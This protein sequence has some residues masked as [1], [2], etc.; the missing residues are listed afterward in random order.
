MKC[1]SCGN[2]VEIGKKNIVRKGKGNPSYSIQCQICG[3]WNTVK[4][5]H[6]T[7]EK[8]TVRISQ[9]PPL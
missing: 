3:K 8:R 2:E 7:G 6:K 9:K 5:R 4:C 1:K